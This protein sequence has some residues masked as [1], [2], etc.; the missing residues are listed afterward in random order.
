MDYQHARQLYLWSFPIVAFANLQVNLE[1]TTG[2]RPG[3]LTW[4]S[5]VPKCVQSVPCFHSCRTS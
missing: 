4:N 5:P 2:A 1:G 3:D